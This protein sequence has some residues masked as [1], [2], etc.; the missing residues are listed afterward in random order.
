MVQP[1]TSPRAFQDHIFGPPGRDDVGDDALGVHRVAGRLAESAARA[2]QRQVFE[3]VVKGT[4][5][6]NIGVHDG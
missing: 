2:A 1:D 3:L 5:D 4:G 6:G